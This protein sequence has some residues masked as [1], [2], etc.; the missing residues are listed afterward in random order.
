MKIIQ[1]TVSPK[2]QTQIK[3]S[4]FAGAECREAS[5]FL[6]TALGQSQSE[7]LSPEFHQSTTADE[8]QRERA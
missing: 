1:I 5:R 8:Q 7:R 4:G 6:E 3:T 2:G